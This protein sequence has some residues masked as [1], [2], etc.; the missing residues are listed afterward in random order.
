MKTKYLVLLFLFIGCSQAIKPEPKFS[1]GQ[2]V[3]YKVSKFFKLV[4]NGEATIDNNIY[5]T[6]SKYIYWLSTNSGCPDFQEAEENIEA[7]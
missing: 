7:L 4:C 5:Y 2:K 1:M 3:T 6:G